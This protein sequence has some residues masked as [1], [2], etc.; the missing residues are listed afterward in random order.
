MAGP[1]SLILL[2]V[3]SALV[4][5]WRHRRYL[6]VGWFWFLGTLLPMI[7]VVFIND[8]AMADRYAYLPFVGLFLMVCWGVA[9]VA[10]Q[11]HLPPAWLAVPS[12]AVLLALA[13]V[14]RH[15]L[16]YWNSDVDLWAHAVAITRNNWVAER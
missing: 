15:Q 9:E 6:L 11:R 8:Q 3:V 4:I 1:S 5:K 13:V 16:A 2:V 12:F 10:S 7:G 14:G